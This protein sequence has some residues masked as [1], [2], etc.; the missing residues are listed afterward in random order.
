MQKLSLR[1]Q[2]TI[3]RLYL[4][5]FSYD[6]IAAKTGVSKGTIANVVAD[7]KAGRILDV[8]VPADQLD[9]LRELA[10]DLR[11]LKLTPD[12]ALVGVA[13]LSHLQELGIEPGDIQHWAAMCREMSATETEAQ[14]FMQAAL[15][16]DEVR[17]R[18]G[19]STKR[20]ESFWELT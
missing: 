4:G 1:K 7:F 8:Q 11:R 5:G 2:L 18:T 16:L 12:Q 14:A 3:V 19:L 13:T 17:V 20:S 9:L 15:A 6:E 10:V